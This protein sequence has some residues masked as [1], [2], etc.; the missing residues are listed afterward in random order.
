M[1]QDLIERL[2]KIAKKNKDKFKY[3]IDIN[4][5]PRDK[6]IV[7]TFNCIETA[8]DHSFTTGSGD[9]IE[10]AVEDAISDIKS[11]LESWGYKE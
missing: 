4:F 9:T 11:A 1:L 10:E 6:K 7:Y 2:E 3:Q 8:D 5:L